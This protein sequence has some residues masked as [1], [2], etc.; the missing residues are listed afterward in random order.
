[1]SSITRGQRLLST[2]GRVGC[3][4]RWE[5]WWPR[6]PRRDGWSWTGSQWAESTEHTGKHRVH[7]KI[8]N[9]SC[10]LWLFNNSASPGSTKR[11]GD[12]KW[13][14]RTYSAK[15]GTLELLVLIICKEQNQQL[16]IPQGFFWCSCVPK[17]QFLEYQIIMKL[18]RNYKPF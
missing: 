4:G 10:N 17:S 8:G 5:G 9:Y 7:A 2:S 14:H 18:A 6:P 11:L 15:A 16:Q 3:P 13:T 12:G 1:M